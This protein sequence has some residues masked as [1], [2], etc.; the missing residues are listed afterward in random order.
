MKQ[1]IIF[2]VS[3]SLNIWIHYTRLRWFHSFAIKNIIKENISICYR[4]AKSSTFCCIMT[5][6]YHCVICNSSMIP[7]LLRQ[8]SVDFYQRRGT[9]YGHF[10][11]CTIDTRVL[12]FPL[13]R[14]CIWS[15]SDSKN[16]Y[17]TKGNVTAKRITQRLRHGHFTLQDFVRHQLRLKGRRTLRS[18]NYYTL[19]SWKHL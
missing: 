11:E 17:E 14:L 9:S 18:T 6:D 1:F 3:M 8:S 2:H 4:A 10:S 16:R 7:G 15:I 13:A 12:K 19:F 5:N